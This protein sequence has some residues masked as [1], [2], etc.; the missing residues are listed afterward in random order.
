MAAALLHYAQTNKAQFQGLLAPRHGGSDPLQP[1][2]GASIEAVRHPT[3]NDPDYLIYSVYG[4]DFE[5]YSCTR[6]LFICENVRPD[7]DQ[8]D[9]AFSF[10]HSPDVR[11]YRLPNYY[12]CADLEHMR[13]AEDVDRLFSEKRRFC[14]FIVGHAG[15]AERENFYRLLSSYRKIDAPG[16]V[17]NNMA[18]L[19]P[20]HQGRW[21]RD[22]VAFMRPYKFSIVFENSSYPGYTTEKLLSALLSNTVGIYWG[23]PRVSLDFNPRSFVNCHDFDDFESVA[24]Y[25]EELDKDDAAYKRY[26]AEPP[27]EGGRVPDSLR[28]PNVLDRFEQIFDR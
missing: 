11:N 7:F 14:N 19:G 12:F 20:A 24:A 26:L 25:V 13:A 15:C 28:T 16:A 22:K 5:R 27:F 6:I 2:R 10:D 23:N 18:G 3:V 17:F 1:V 9:Y 21:F 8:C 4:Q